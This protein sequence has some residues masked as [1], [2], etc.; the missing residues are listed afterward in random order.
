[1]LGAILPETDPIWEVPVFAIVG[2]VAV[3]GWPFIARRLG[4]TG[5]DV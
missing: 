3:A 2:F 5:R 4:L 1:L